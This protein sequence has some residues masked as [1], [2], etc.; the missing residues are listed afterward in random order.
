MKGSLFAG[1]AVV[2]LALGLSLAPAWADKD[3][4]EKG[5]GDH[6]YRTHEMMGHHGSTG[7]FLRHLLKHGKEIGLTDEQVAKLKTLQL[8]LDKTRI[9][10]EADILIAERELAAM[11]ED[12]KTD[13]G[14]IEAKLKQSE[15]MEASLRMAAIKAKRDAWALLTPEQREKEQAEHEKMLRHHREGRHQEG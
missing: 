8:E 10:M 14:V 9:K 13:L 15:G 3:G 1:A 11:V 12:D 2:M 6:G 7:H 4:H 5:Y